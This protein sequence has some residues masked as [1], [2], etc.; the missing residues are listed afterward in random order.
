[1]KHATDAGVSSEAGAPEATDWTSYGHDLS[2]TRNSPETTFST[3]NVG[4][5]TRKWEKWLP[6]CTSTP[7]VVNG[8]V[9]L[10]DWFGSLHA[11]RVQDGTDVWTTQLTQSTIDDSPLVADGKIFVGD[12][13]GK[14]YSVDQRTGKL[15]WSAV[16]SDHPQ[17][18][19]YSSPATVDG[20]VLIGSASLELVSGVNEFTFK[21]SFVA[22]D[23]NTG[24][25]E[26]RT[27][28]AFDDERSGA[29]VSVWS[30]F[31]IDTKREMAFIGTGQSYEAPA[32]EYGDSLVAVKYKTGEIVWHQQYTADDIYTILHAQGPDADVGATPNLITVNGVDAV[33]VGNKAGKFAV[34]NRD[35]GA[36]LWDP[37][38]QQVAK[39]SAQGGFMASSAYN[40]GVIYMASNDGIGL[41]DDPQPTDT[42]ALLAVNADTGATVWRKE[43]PYP[44]VGGVTY[45][46]GLLFYTTT[47]GTINAIDASTGDQLWSDKTSF[48]DPRTGDRNT[49]KVAAGVTVAEGEVF[50]CSGFS[51][52]KTS[53][54]GSYGGGVIAYGLPGG[55]ENLPDGGAADSHQCLLPAGAS[56]CNSTVT[57]INLCPVSTAC[58]CEKCDCDF[59]ACAEHP[60]CLDILNCSIQTGCAQSNALL[61]YL[62]DGPCK[63]VIDANGGP[64]GPAT[65]LALAVGDCAAAQSCPQ[66]CP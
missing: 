52:F 16:V 15:L 13:A 57:S 63:D 18:H 64:V 61:C 49:Y 19:V 8:I 29:G 58:I 31:A 54:N 50:V 11:M 60:G 32:S 44:S 46:N 34:F 43:R 51:F 35:T 56:Q 5:L 66:A 33:G 62:N 55:V 59:Q 26:W 30:S 6:R 39:G 24:K 40:D 25:E 47:D 21:G 36:P 14:L 53:G 17:A 38:F 41:I 12:G 23:E 1:M 2:Q 65:N 45:T 3:A 22:F 10:G 4:Q 20:L 7:A 27:Y 42:H 28:V 37:M 9:Y 48:I